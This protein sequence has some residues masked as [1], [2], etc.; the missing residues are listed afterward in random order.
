[1]GCTSSR[2][3]EVEVC[4]LKTLWITSRLTGVSRII[5]DFSSSN[6]IVHLEWP[7]GTGPQANSMI[8]AS[9]RPLS[10]RL[11]L[12]ELTLCLNSVM[13]SIPPS[14][15]F[16]TVLVTVARHT[17]FDFVDCSWVNTF[18]WVSSRPI[19]IWH[20]HQIVLDNLFLRMTDFKKFNSSSVSSFLYFLGLATESHR[21]FF[22]YARKRQ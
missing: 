21:R 1:M 20:L 8:R 14:K 3:C 10:T 12:S 9:A 13:I 18:P 4:F 7:S 16:F 22:Y 11:A 15:Y 5:L 17:P 6:C 19:M 2:F